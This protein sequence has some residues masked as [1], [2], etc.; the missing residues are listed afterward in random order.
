MAKNHSRAQGLQE[1]IRLRLS[2][3]LELGLAVFRELLEE[4]QGDGGNRKE[5]GQRANDLPG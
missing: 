5:H 2:A 3:R 1:A 4:G